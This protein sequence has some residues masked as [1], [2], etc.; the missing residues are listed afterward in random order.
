[1]KSAAIKHSRES[2]HSITYEKRYTRCGKP[3]CEREHG[4][5]WYAFWTAGGRVRTVYVGKKFRR[6]SSFKP[7]ALTKTY[8]PC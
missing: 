4:P 2:G 3:G 7:E 5:Y 8:P 6:V 1:M